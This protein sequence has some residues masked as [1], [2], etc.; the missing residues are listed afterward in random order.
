MQQTFLLEVILKELVTLALRT[1]RLLLQ[2]EQ[3]ELMTD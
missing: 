2:I 1:G 3:E